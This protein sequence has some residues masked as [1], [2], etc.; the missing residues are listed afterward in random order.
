MFR[1]I[2]NPFKDKQIDH[3]NHNTLDNRKENLRIVTGSQNGMNQKLH[4]NNTSGYKGVHWFIYSKRWMAYIRLNSRKIH[5]GYFNSKIEAAYAYNYA[6]LKYFGK[7][8]KLNNI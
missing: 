7:F 2:V 1:I 5:L 4:K 8:A 6:A 3:I